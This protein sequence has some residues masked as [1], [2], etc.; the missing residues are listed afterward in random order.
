[1]TSIH[2][3]PPSLRCGICYDLYYKPT[4]LVT[5]NH[6]FCGTCLHLAYK[7]SDSCPLC[8]QTFTSVTK[9]VELCQQIHEYLEVNPQC[10]YSSE[11]LKELSSKKTVPCDVDLSLKNEE[12]IIEVLVSNNPTELA[13]LLRKC[14]RNICLDEVRVAKNFSLLTYACFMGYYECVKV[15]LD[16][17]LDSNSRDFDGYTPLAI[18]SRR[19][20]TSCV[21]LLCE[22]GADL[23]KTSDHYSSC[24]TPLMLASREG[25]L[26]AVVVL[27]EAGAKI[28]THCNTGSALVH[29]S[30]GGHTII[31]EYLLK[32]GADV[33]LKTDDLNG[34]LTA[35][36]AA[37]GKNHMNCVHMLC[38]YGADINAKN[39]KGC[40]A[41]MSAVYE[42]N[43]PMVHVLLYRDADVN[44]RNNAG[45]TP[46]SVSAYTGDVECMTLLRRYKADLNVRDDAGYTALMVACMKGEAPCVELLCELGADLETAGKDGTTPLLLAAVKGDNECARHLIRHGANVNIHSGGSSSSKGVSLLTIA[47]RQLSI[48]TTSKIMLSKAWSSCCGRV[49]SPYLSKPQT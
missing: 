2:E 38:K 42:G 7:T 1:M 23:E 44:C 46:L 5:C 10:N 39:A 27:N 47:S 33:S 32:H 30:S 24:F 18:S 8:R 20:H 45:A 21:K 11:T 43:A 31:V 3:I 26:E 15:L 40:T 9:N 49:S 48:R 36:M 16:H 19:G 34:G 12:V 4:K 22:Y 28:N 6:S 35:L 25:H 13:S 29:A 17:G 37:A 14:D 41:L